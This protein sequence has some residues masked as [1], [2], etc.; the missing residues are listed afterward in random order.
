MTDSSQRDN[1]TTYTATYRLAIPAE[2]I[3]RLEAEYITIPKHRVVKRYFKRRLIRKVRSI[4][5]R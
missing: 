5:E 4:Y 3:A 2:H 1:P